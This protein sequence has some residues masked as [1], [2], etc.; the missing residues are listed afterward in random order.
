[1]EERRKFPRYESAFEV[2]YSPR[3]DTET[4]NYTVSKNI[5]KGGIRLP[6]S[7]VVK[8]G[9]TINLD[10][11]ISQKK[12]GVSAIGKVRWV[13]EIGRPSPLGLE[14]GLEFT[15]IDPRDVERLLKTVY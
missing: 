6:V 10:I 14:A 7:R 8:N 1:M 5:S 11:D 2:K 3:G 4:D 15:K 12:G 9:D 13:K